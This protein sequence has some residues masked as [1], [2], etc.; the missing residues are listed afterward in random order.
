MYGYDIFEA[1]L[2]GLGMA[3]FSNH[4]ALPCAYDFALLGHWL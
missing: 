4:R 2:K 1:A 3:R